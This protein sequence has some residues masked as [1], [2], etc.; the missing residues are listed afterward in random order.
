[1]RVM[2]LGGTS[3]GSAERM[4]GAMRLVGAAVTES[5]VLVVAS[6]VA[7]VTNLLIEG[8]RT[9]AEG[10]DA[11]A[12]ERFRAVHRGILDELAAAGTLVP[13]VRDQVLR[14]LDELS[15]ERRGTGAASATRPTSGPG[16]R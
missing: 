5:R 12:G 3:V 7:G 16:C 10:G 9:A 13:E 14:A 6:A 15:A 8:A 2:K 1:M 4:R 11:G